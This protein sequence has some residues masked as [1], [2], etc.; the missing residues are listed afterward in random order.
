MID[1][2]INVC[3]ISLF[4]G[5]FTSLLSTAVTAIGTKTEAIDT[6]RTNHFTYFY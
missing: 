4:T 5:L 6:K 2:L 3:F 1:Q